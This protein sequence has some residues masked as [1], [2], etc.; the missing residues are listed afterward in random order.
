MLL[1]AGL[2]AKEPLGTWGADL[3][4]PVREGCVCLGRSRREL[5][6]KKY[7]ASLL[8]VSLLSA[9]VHGH[10]PQ[11]CFLWRGEWPGISPGPIC[12]QSRPAGAGARGS[13]F[14]WEPHSL[15]GL[16]HRPFIAALELCLTHTQT[17]V[18][19]GLG[20]REALVTVPEVR[21]GERR[22]SEPGAAWPLP[23]LG[24]GPAV[25]HLRASTPCS[26]GVPGWGAR[27]SLSVCW[28]FGRRSPSGP[29]LEAWA[30]RRAEYLESAVEF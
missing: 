3:R 14:P 21:Q 15:P 22:G 8:G 12:H 28:R 9:H 19:G 18:P 4:R 6:Q 7:K 5:Q 17:A 27:L 20:Q 29:R 23:S 26:S 16:Q 2:G 1:L 10:P 13:R 11:P 25:C 30:L 24:L